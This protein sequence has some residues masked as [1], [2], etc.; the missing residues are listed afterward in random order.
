MILG[1]SLQVMASLAARESL[2]GKVQCDYFDPPDR[3]RFN[4]NWQVSTRSRD[5]KDGSQADILAP[6]ERSSRAAISCPRIGPF[7]WLA[8]PFWSDR[9]TG[10]P[11]AGHFSYAIVGGDPPSQKARPD[12]R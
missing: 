3:I 9:P 1:D 10:N 2:R 11:A 8:A 12:Q 4:S 7:Q 6:G 5:V